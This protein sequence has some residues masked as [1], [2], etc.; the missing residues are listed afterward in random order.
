M[1]ETSL[2]ALLVASCFPHPQNPLLGVWALSQAEAVRGA[3]VDLR[4]VSPTSYVPRFAGSLG[5]APWA[6]NCPPEATI[7]SLQVCYPKWPVYHLGLM[8]KVTRRNPSLMLALGW[9]VIRRSVL[10]EVEKHQPDVVFAHHSFEG[11]EIARRIK[12]ETGLNYVTAD[13]DFGEITDCQIFPRRAAHYARVLGQAS[14]VL[15]TSERMKRDLVSQFPGVRAVVAHYGR[16]PLPTEVMQRSRPTDRDGKLIVLC[17]AGFYER[18]GLPVLIEAFSRV[19]N[20]HTNAELWIAGGGHDQGLV[21]RALQSSGAQRVRL[22]GSL[23]HQ[24][25]LQE[26]VWADIFALVGWDEPFATVYVEALAAG[27]PIICCDDG[28]I[29]DVVRDGVEAILVPPRN[30]E[31]TAQA[32]RRLLIDQSLRKRMSAASAALFHSQLT[33]SAYAQTILA[34]LGRAAR[35][36]RKA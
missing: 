20:D 19:E 10:K 7:G 35:G 34:E 13:W 32:L 11:G 12:L 27:K 25:L 21:D 5:V 28:G 33:T 26:M 23:P 8:R 9:Q 24:Q 14:C 4:V 15:A 17:A 18:K 31:A 22:L 36:E 1:V 29:C 16:D 30:V 6:A 3:G 2:R